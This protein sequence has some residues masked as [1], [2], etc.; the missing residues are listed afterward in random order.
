MKEKIREAAIKTLGYII[1]GLWIVG[2]VIVPVL[3][4]C[5]AIK[6]IAVMFGG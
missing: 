5:G 4:I 3:I 1:A 6:L 2:L